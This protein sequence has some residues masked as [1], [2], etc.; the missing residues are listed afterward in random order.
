VEDKT[1]NKTDYNLFATVPFKLFEMKV[2]V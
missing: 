1:R 2:E